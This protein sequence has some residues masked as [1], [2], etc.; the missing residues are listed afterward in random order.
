MFDCHVFN[1]ETI[2]KLFASAYYF[3]FLLYC[4]YLLVWYILSTNAL[5]NSLSVKISSHKFTSAGMQ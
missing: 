5:S 1:K 4:S 2:T 3:N